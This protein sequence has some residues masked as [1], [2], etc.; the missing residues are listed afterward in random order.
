MGRKRTCDQEAVLDAFARKLTL[1]EI[2]R[3][4]GGV[5]IGTLGV[6]IHRARKAGDP[7][8]GLRRPATLP[9]AADVAIA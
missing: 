5:P 1:K 9:P 4:L 7:R 2:S 6:I 8:A 3:S